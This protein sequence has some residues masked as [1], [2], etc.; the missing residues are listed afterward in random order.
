MGPTSRVS[1]REIPVDVL[2]DASNTARTLVVVLDGFFTAC[3]GKL[4]TKCGGFSDQL[5]ELV[6]RG[7][8]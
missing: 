6:L 4:K 8:W 1:F 2:A 3:M 5:Q 7:P